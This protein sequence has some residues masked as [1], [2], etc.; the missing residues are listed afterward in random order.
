MAKI[1]NM[2]DIGKR[3]MS[4][5]GT[6]LQVA[7]HNIAGRSVENFSRQRVEIQTNVPITEGKLQLGM[8]ARAGNVTRVNNPFL[9]KQIQK[10][11]SQLGYADGRA[12]NMSRIEQVYN[13]Q[14]NKGLNTS[15]G[16]FFNSFRELA[17]QPESLAS[18]TLVR[19]AG[20]TMGQD[21]EKINRQLK[22][23][24]RDIDFQLKT[25]VDQLNQMS[26]EI[27]SLNQKIMQA[28]NLGT[29][30]N[31]EKDR[32]DLLL[33]KMGEKIDISFGEDKFGNIAV[34]AGKIGILVSGSS[35]NE[36]HCTETGARDRAE[37][38]FKNSENGS[39]FQV[40]DLA[41]GG[42]I[43]A[44]IE[45]RDKVIE[46]LLGSVD[47]MAHSMMKEV[48]AAHIEG[49]DRYGKEGILFFD[50]PDQVK[51]A[52]AVVKI[53]ETINKD[54]G[55]ISVAARPDAPGD[56]TVANVISSLQYQ[57]IMAHG[58][59]TFDDYYNTSVGQIGTV[60]QRAVKNH[61]SQKNIVDQLGN[62]RESVSGVSLDEEATKM[63]EF[64]KAYDA[65][66]RLIRVADEMYDTVLNLKRL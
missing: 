34:H 25:D 15:I 39:S 62:I 19:E 13:E 8:G 43:G 64:Q 60:V 47:T 48:N 18:R 30:P 11:T 20:L 31:D 42:R 10:E 56:N 37:I 12:E 38:F 32:R 7:G 63:I 66:A 23:I 6:A 52:A 45:V 59:A 36:L 17:N 24:Q 35:A 54:V 22:D 2:M 28:E 51:G 9:E 50:M 41:T 61:E 55:K 33:K 46:D 1:S 29:S 16:A 57:K 53:N 3:S 58:Q 5:S 26:K 21:F 27:A 49:F 4:N 40:T 65:S 14:L 44:G